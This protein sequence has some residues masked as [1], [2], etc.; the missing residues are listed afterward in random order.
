M[1]PFSIL[2]A[3]DEPNIREALH[4]AL[5]GEGYWVA[6]A[7]SG[8][9]TLSQLEARRFQLVLLD[10]VLGDMDG[11]EI[12][13]A[14]KEKWP[15]TEVV[16]IT[17]Y[18]TI[19]TAVEALREGAYD[20]MT[21]PINL[22]RL[23]SY[24]QKICRA[25]RLEDENIRLR[26]ELSR[27]RQYRNIVGCS[28]ALMEVLDLID[29]VAPTDV[30]VLILGETG[31]GKELVARAIHQRS[32]RS[33][34]PFISLNCGA[35]PPDLFESE[36]FGYEKGAFT[37][38]HN[39]KPGRYEMAHGGTLFLDEIA[40]M[41]ASSQVDFLRL[42]EEGVVHRLGST[43]P[44][45]VD[46]RVLA[47]TNKDLEAL[48]RQGQFRE[49][50]YYRLNVVSITLPP[51]RER[52]EDV[53]VL[54]VHFLEEFKEKYRRPEL[55]FDPGVLEDL[56]A[57]SWPGN[58]RELRNAVERAAVLCRGNK[59]TRRFFPFLADVSGP[60]GPSSE[61]VQEPA[62]YPAPWTL[63]QVEKAHIARAL[64]FHGGH[65]RKTA[66]S[67]GISERDLYYKIKRYGISA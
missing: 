45:E 66:K 1:E 19:E 16:V 27:E 63:A 7:S 65:R 50:L 24:V 67:L 41:A 35:L 56:K 52:K 37:G 5:A 20:Y 64:E 42:L 47:A 25:K 22:K 6:T 21:K 51:L 18:G 49:D 44:L 29:Q 61:T 55:V 8:R 62:G 10:L 17:A 53:P 46:V 23:R 14:V 32:F 12:L 58:I 28:D 34:G 60:P 9:Q 30:P 48:C 33:S 3:D 40:E 15:R 59:I 31:T 54:A 43:R 36:L 13:K 11:M 38:A 57:Y 26:E 2:I 39:R 4:E